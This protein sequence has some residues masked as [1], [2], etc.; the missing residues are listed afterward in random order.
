MKIS[1]AA[2]DTLDQTSGESK[3]MILKGVSHGVKEHNLLSIIYIYIIYSLDSE[4]AI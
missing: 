2:E 1:T 4:L 3:Y